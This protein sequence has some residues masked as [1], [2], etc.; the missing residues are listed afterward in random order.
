MATIKLKIHKRSEYFNN[1]T[2]TGFIIVGT[3][4]GNVVIERGRGSMLD[5]EFRTK[6]QAQRWIDLY[7]GQSLLCAAASKRGKS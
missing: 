6:A 1:P 7:I 5:K 3:R 2:E 4:E